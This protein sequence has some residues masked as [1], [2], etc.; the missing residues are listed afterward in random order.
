MAVALG[1]VQHW[2]PESTALLVAVKVAGF[3]VPAVIAARYPEIAR[4]R[5]LAQLDSTAGSTAEA[6]KGEAPEKNLRPC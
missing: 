3:T 5:H 4:R 1:C 2:A 6:A